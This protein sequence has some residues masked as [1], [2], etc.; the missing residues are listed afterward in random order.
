M[1]L[2]Y[3]ILLYYIYYRDQHFKEILTHKSKKNYSKPCQTKQNK[4]RENNNRRIP[5]SSKIPCE[6]FQGFLLVNMQ[7]K[8]IH[9]KG[10]S[11]GQTLGVDRKI[12]QCWRGPEGS[13][14]S[15]SFKGFHQ[16]GF[17]L[18]LPENGWNGVGKYDR[19]F[20]KS[21]YKAYILSFRMFQV[22]PM[23]FFPGLFGGF[24]S[25][26]LPSLPDF[27][28]RSTLGHEWSAQSSPHAPHESPAS[29]AGC[30]WCAHCPTSRH[31][32]GDVLLKVEDE[33]DEG[34]E[35][36]KCPINLDRFFF[37]WV[38]SCST[39]TDSQFQFLFE[40]TFS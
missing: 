19:F 16:T 33:W 24:F 26:K 40:V 14:G 2:N 13:D 20:L 25:T 35:A 30:E 29:H 3:Y 37:W 6:I 15:C 23:D 10:R 28:N 18:T 8:S 22:A 21:V 7:Q 34:L 36:T 9:T 27:R 11:P 32:S 38:T 31:P 4:S 17:S 12:C 1:V 5:G 39:R